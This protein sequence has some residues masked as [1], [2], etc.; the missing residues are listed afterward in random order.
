MTPL[1]AAEN[2]AGE[3]RIRLAELAAETE[4]TDEH[5]A[6]LDE[7]RREYG[8]VERRMTAL[9]IAEP[10]PAPIER[11]TEDVQLAGLVKQANVG[12]ILSAVLEHRATEGPAAEMQQHFGLA[13]NQIPLEMLTGRRIETR[14]AATIT[15]DVEANQQ[16]VL[17]IVFP[18]SVS[19][20]L[21][22]DQPAVSPG[23]ALF[24][25]LTSG[26][27]PGTPAKSGTQA[28][29]TAT[30]VAHS[31][32]P[33]RVQAALRY[34]REDAARFP[35]L[36]ASLRTNL[37]DSLMDKLD[38]LNINDATNGLLGTASVTAGL[39]NPTNPSAVAGF[40]DYI[41]TVY[42]SV[43]GTY[44]RMAGDVRLLMAVAAYQHAGTV[45]RGNASDVPGIE[46]VMRIAGGV[47]TTP[48][49][50]NAP[51]TGTDAN[52]QT[53]IARRGMRRDYV[54]PVWNA[55]SL[56]FDEYT[57][58]STGEIIL[59]A[60]LLSGRRLLRSDGFRR[61]EVQTA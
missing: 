59:T 29:N 37:S 47:M 34:T 60:Y 33:S 42:Q 35:D 46:H 7:L 26:A 39:A 57:A 20:Y 1:K 15:G 44:A 2:R 23:L 8:D 10:E 12:S 13:G 22:I 45:F 40:G 14:A 16:P 21:G 17:D 31:I 50:A 53:I 11:R 48:H 58:A 32:E 55:V 4:L 6:E 38:D 24:P 43:D 28:E 49:I 27:A 61:I 18:E 19:A 36:D 30:F 54:N 41:N 9:R 3:I 52:D 51:T 5:R 25:V 56:V